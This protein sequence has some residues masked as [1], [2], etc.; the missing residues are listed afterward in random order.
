MKKLIPILLLTAVAL[1]G[2][3]TGSKS[4]TII[5]YYS[6]VGYAQ[7]QPPPP[8]P[9]PP[10]QIIYRDREVVRERRIVS[11]RQ[12]ELSMAELGDQ[13]GKK[14]IRKMKAAYNET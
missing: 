1:T 14:L 3:T 13:L 9:P 7:A 11:Y 5:N 12:R 8:P 4:K 10:P 2:C 6:N